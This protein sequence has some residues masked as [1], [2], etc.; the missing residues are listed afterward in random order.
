MITTFYNGISGVKSHQFGLDSWSNNVANVNTYGYKSSVPRFETIFERQMDTISFNAPTA[1]DI[2]HGVT[3]ASNDIDMTAGS[4][5]DANDS[6]Y[7]M[8]VQG[9]GW[10]VVGTKSAIT[11]EGQNNSYNGIY[12]TRDGS[13][14]RDESGYIVTSGGEYLYGVDLGKVSNGEYKTSYNN[15]TIE[16]SEKKDIETL[17]STDFNTLKPLQIP[18]NVYYK[19]N[20]TTEVKTSINLNSTAN[21]NMIDKIYKDVN[22]DFDVEK[23]KKTDFNALYNIDKQKLPLQEGDT[24][25]IK[26]QTT[27]IHDEDYAEGDAIT[28]IDEAIQK[29]A[30]DA[31]NPSIKVNG[32][33]QTFST[34]EDIYD[35]LTTNDI[36]GD[37]EFTLEN[38][39]IYSISGEKGFKS[40]GEFMNLINSTTALSCEID[41]CRI[42][43]KNSSDDTMKIQFGSSNYSFLE[44]LGLKDFEYINIPKEEPLVTSKI[45]SSGYSTYVEIFDEN[46]GKNVVKTDYSLRQNTNN[47][48]KPEMW[49]LV[50]SVYSKDDTEYK[51]PLSDSIKSV[52]TFNDGKA[53]IDKPIELTYINN[54]TQKVSFDPVGVNSNSFT[55]NNKYEIS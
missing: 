30:G 41:E 28:Y 20:I 11:T 37:I 48:D 38:E 32:S 27:Y 24:V 3:V 33:E 15:L 34:A 44:S 45:A 42:A 1:S 18:D 6:E 51:T 17:T 23:F 16:E 46:G 55:S 43:F 39:Y 35:Y 22:G 40:V 31:I 2:G 7:N 9:D 29:L 50:T 21:I 10:F 53:S 12:F 26:L 47:T 49:D 19:P 14:A 25:N 8:A 4:Y 5:V 54:N 36:T 13:F 52:V